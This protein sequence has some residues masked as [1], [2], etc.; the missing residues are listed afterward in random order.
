MSISKIKEIMELPL[1]Q[2][3]QG[4]CLKVLK[5][6]PSGSVDL[7]VTDPPYNMAY[8]GRGFLN[9]FSSFAN[10]DLTPEE[11]SKWFDKIVKE[12]YRV[13]KDDTAI[14]IWIDWRNYAR[15][16]PIIEKYFDIKNCIVWDK[17]TIG[18]GKHY[19]FQHELCIFAVKGDYKHEDHS[20]SDIWRFKREN[21][22]NTSTLLKSH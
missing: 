9:K 14:Y 12:L 18:M 8:S 22:A 13:L 20:K 2:V 3:I 5:E 21:T 6:L 17:E 4:D 15:I 11:H 7:V 19:R 10:D 1:N 16:Y